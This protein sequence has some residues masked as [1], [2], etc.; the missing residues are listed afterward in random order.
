MTVKDRARLDDHYSRQARQEGFPARSV[1]KLEEFDRKYK[2]FRPGQRVLDLG[3]APGSWTLYAAGKVGEK[4]RVVG[5]DLTAPGVA[6]PPQV[7]IEQADLLE[8]R[9]ELVAGEGPF[10]VILSDLAPKTS[11]RREVDQA[12]SLELCRVAWFWA[13]RLLR[14]GGRF[15]FKLFQ[16]AEGDAFVLSLAP[17]FRKITR[18]KPK[19]TRARSVEIFVLAQGLGR[20]GSADA[21]L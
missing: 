13:E 4:G 12:R 21:A 20:V 2:L 7:R 8:N 17:R 19:A 15:L 18:L 16:S 6:F 11:G 3:C 10:D 14:P 5:L 9:L 1:Y